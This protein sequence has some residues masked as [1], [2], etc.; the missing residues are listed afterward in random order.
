MNEFDVEKSTQSSRDGVSLE[1]FQ[2]VFCQVTKKS[3]RE[4]AVEEYM[5]LQLRSMSDPSTLLVASSLSLKTL[6]LSAECSLSVN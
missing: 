2:Y 4:S 3:N 1:L 5:N 6:F